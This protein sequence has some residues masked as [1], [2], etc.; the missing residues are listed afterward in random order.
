MQGNPLRLETYD[1]SDSDQEAAEKL[2]DG[3]D[4]ESPR[5]FDTS[6]QKEEQPS[7]SIKFNIHYAQ[8][9][10]KP[11]DPNRFGR[12]RIF[13]AVTR[14]NPKELEGLKE[15]LLKTLKFLTDSEFTDGKTGKTCLMK[16]L[17]NLK[18]GGNPTIPL[19]LSIDEETQNPKPLVNVPCKDNYYKG[20][21]ALHIAIEKRNLG[22]VK[23]LVE[24]GANVHAKACGM[25]F[26][27]RKKGACFY[28][29][30]LPFSLAA[31][32]NQPEVM[33]YLLHNPHQQ[34]RLT[35]QDSLGNTVLHALVTV[36]DNT[37]KNTELVIKMYNMILMEGARIN[38]TWKMEEIVN[39]EGLTP[40][41]L[42]V[43]TGKAEI[44]KHMIRREIKDPDFR[45]LSRKFTEWTYGPIHISLYDMS[46]IDSY[47]ENS[48]LEILAYSNDTPN[49]YKMVV[50]EPVN[51]LLQHKWD[52]FAA[53]RFYLSF[54]CYVMFLIIFS[55][56]AYHWRLDGK[57]PF[58]MT[59][60]PGDIWR[61]I[62]QV[63]VFLG[64]LYLFLAQ[65]VYLWRRRQS[66]KSLLVDGC[67]EFFIFV[68]SAALLLAA[69]TYLAGL[70]EH[71]IFLVFSL[72]LGWVNVL[73][74][75]R[76][77][78]Q[79]GIY[80]VMI[81]KAILRDLL[82]FIM[83]YVIFLFGFA[84]ALIIL[85]ATTP[86]LAQNSSAPLDGDDKGPAMY[87][88]LFKTSLE[89]FKFTIGMGD[90]EFHE[91]VRFKY[92]VMLLLLL[93]VIFTYILLLNML[94]ALMSETV[95]NVSGY[96]Q[97]VWK[98]QRA[99]AILEIE[100]NWVWCW[101]KP[102]RAGYF[103]NVGSETKK[104]ERWLFRV[105]EVNW[106]D[107]KKEVGALKEDP[108]DANTS[109]PELEAQSILSQ[110][111]ARIMARTATPE[112]DEMPLHD[113]SP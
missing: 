38:P 98:L 1:G 70:E 37:E 56:T 29:G 76:G 34:A 18:D 105:Q 11:K 96:S 47:E 104:D 21:T 112:E 7:P 97:S 92:F 53:R 83:V 91:H 99:I 43:K 27:Q 12:D 15:Y 10:N 5:P 22:L 26:Q 50:L 103:L 84:T 89:L 86:Q 28:F 8:G 111:S 59:P 72:L 106:V 20:H 102:P 95:T 6:F 108:A 73:Y 74:Y 90:L 65:S 17:L 62:G 33:D 63:I 39:K 57:P 52:S 42:A 2:D 100:K 67:I 46:F 23:L 58:P 66:W 45:H 61:L 75:T 82:H 51:K 64:G 49:R 87:T 79:M 24:N 88:G 35:E 3:A 32:T 113:I 44:F 68:Q 101:A 48:V 9:H 78:Q 40:L 4:T 41:K 93:F 14:G 110:L 69:V 30:E 85:T 80:I 16:A 13:G 25:F 107:W 71:V 55:A 31:C 109:K 94:I 54:A 81:Q 77:F 36:A 19:L 60:S